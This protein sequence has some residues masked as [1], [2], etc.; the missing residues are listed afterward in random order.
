M[1]IEEQFVEIITKQKSDHLASFLKVLSPEQKKLLTPSIKKL[2]KEYSEY[3]NIGGNRWGHIKGTDRQRKMLQCAS[4]VCLNRADYEKSPSPVWFIDQENLKHIID[5]YVPDWFS[6]YVNK[7]ASREF[8][9][10]EYDWIIELTNKGALR[11]SRELLVKS[12]PQMIFEKNDREWKYKPENLL[13]HPVTLQEHIWYLFELESNLHYS[14]RFVHFGSDVN[15]DTLGWKQIFITYSNEGRI[16]RKRLL[17]ESLLASNKSFNKILS[18]WFA[19][20]FTDLQPA[21]EELLSLQKEIFSILNSPH[22]KVV[23][24]ALQL[25]KKIAAEKNWDL[26]GFLDAAPVLLTSAT[27]AT[28]ASA[29][30][31]LEKV[32]KKHKEHSQVISKLICQVFL[33][34]DDELQTKAAKLILAHA[35]PETENIRE[36]LRVFSTSM[37]TSAKKILAEFISAPV[38]SGEQQDKPDGPGEITAV[39]LTPIPQIETIDDL[40]FLISQAFDNNE[41]WHLEQVVSELIRFHPRLHPDDFIRFQPAFQRALNLASKGL[42]SNM[43]YLEQL[44]AM[45]II[46]YGNYLVRKFPG[47]SD[48]INNIYKKYDN[49]AGENVQSWTVSP[50]NSS[51]TAEWSVYSKITA[52]EPHKH[53]LVAAL[54]KIMKGDDLPFLSVPT[55]TPGWIMPETFIDRLSMYQQNNREPDNIDF[56]VAISRCYLMDTEAVYNYAGGKL[57]GE[58]LHLVRF[59]LD[60]NSQPEGDFLHRAAWMAASLSKKEKKV[61]PQFE[62]FSYYK[63]PF[64]NYTAQLRWDTVD[65]EYTYERYD[66]N[67]KK[68]VELKDRRKL[69]RVFKEQGEKKQ[70]GIRKLFS[71]LMTAPKDDPTLLYDLLLIKVRYFSSEHND[72]KRIILMTPN[73]PEPILTDIIMCC[74]DAPIFVGESDKKLMIATLQVL[75]E[76]WSDP[77][78]MSHLAIGACMISSDKTVANIAGEIWINAVTNDQISNEKLGEVIGLHERIEFAPLKRFTDLV[79]QQLFRIS[80]KH[81]RA[82]QTVVENIL[83]RL[84]EKPITNLKKLLEVYIELVAANNSPVADTVILDKLESWKKTTS[85]QK[86][87]D[88]LLNS[89]NVWV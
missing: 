1:T 73:N 14:D 23:N 72:I 5:W 3:G 9:S 11:P 63:K 8:F 28:V 75:H 70:S 39:A 17:K 67:A 31:I 55:H 36:E 81:N 68:N 76:I 58:Y 29:I 34:A 35:G 80:D 62:N 13:T 7:T 40:V 84:P 12:M 47:V 56:Q 42:R 33:H 89:K 43:G 2:S 51:Y 20:L 52:Y 69:L 16:E 10:L 57:S 49:K 46:D 78:E 86:A 59:L 45:F 83:K 26:H 18:G 41:T 66:Y 4:F 87:A 50:E 85:L 64:N 30:M 74:L 22:S 82:L 27:K 48:S 32:A 53:L 21:T 61:Y 19:Q 6:D 38:A 37:L 77:G 15:K 88:V 65:E 54:N 44:L 24:T 25:I 79:T 60:K 71:G